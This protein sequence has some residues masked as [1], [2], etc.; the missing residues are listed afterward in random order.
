MSRS[1]PDHQQGSPAGPAYPSYQQPQRSA[2]PYRAGA[3]KPF[4]SQSS[5][6]GYNVSND[7]TYSQGH[8]VSHQT[9]HVREVP[10]SHTFQPFSPQSIDPFSQ[11]TLYGSTVEPRGGAPP[12][13]QPPSYFQVETQR[14]QVAYP[15]GQQV[16]QIPVHYEGHSKQSENEPKMYGHYDVH[17]RAQPC[18]SH[19]N[20]PVQKSDQNQHGAGPEFDQPMGHMPGQNGHFI[21]V[22][23]V[24]TPKQPPPPSNGQ[25]GAEQPTQQAGYRPQFPYSDQSDDLQYSQAADVMS[26]H[27]TSQTPMS[28]ASDSG[29]PCTPSMSSSVSE[30]S[31]L[32]SFSEGKQQPGGQAQMTTGSYSVA[33]SDE[34]VEFRPVTQPPAGP[35]AGHPP[36]LAV[37]PPKPMAPSPPGVDDMQAYELPQT[38]PGQEYAMHE[39]PAPHHGPGGSDSPPV[40]LCGPAISHSPVE[41]RTPD[42][43]VDEFGPV[44]AHEPV[45]PKTPGEG[46]QM[47]FSPQPSA[48]P[49]YNDQAPEAVGDSAFGRQQSFPAPPPPQMEEFAPGMEAGYSRQNSFPLPPPPEEQEQPQTPQE[50]PAPPT[51]ESRPEPPALTQSPQPPPPPPPPPLPLSLSPK[52]NQP[53]PTSLSPNLQT[54]PHSP[55]APGLSPGQQA[56]GLSPRQ[57]PPG[58]SPRHV[59]PGLS[60][61]LSPL[62][63]SPGLSPVPAPHGTG[64]SPVPGAGL[65]PIP[66]PPPMH[67]LSPHPVEPVKQSSPSLG[68]SSAGVPKPF[69]PGTVQS[70]PTLP[71]ASPHNISPSAAPPIPG[72]P[73]ASLSPPSQPPAPMS[74]SPGSQSSVT[75]PGSLGQP[76]PAGSLEQP[77]P[78]TT[79]AYSPNLPWLQGNKPQSSS[80]SMEHHPQDQQ[81]PALHSPQVRPDEFPLVEAGPQTEKVSEAPCPPPPVA[82]PPP[83]PP[84]PPPMPSA[85]LNSWNVKRNQAPASQGQ[86][87]GQVTDARPSVL[88]VDSLSLV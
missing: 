10:V 48:P 64:Q 32:S 15:A 29:Y 28:Q 6:D 4:S 60:P 24:H 74:S 11:P 31:D 76:S 12:G 30:L 79:R 25:Y 70:E 67:G 66:P 68:E 3:P 57:L 88:Q 40:E 50:F 63:V 49:Y 75:L 20:I 21:P 22:Q 71:Q 69:S 26:G 38:T 59:S 8:P 80:P 34:S 47:P 72:S 85:P 17:Q 36:G 19:T 53:S 78:D 33:P 16:H 52:P 82:P 44:V 18:P 55:Q 73:H 43:P 87:P 86:G 83:P 56:P 81:T 23:V 46:S 13:I 7:Y 41:P 54:S 84:P 9:P 35:P 45:T 37:C 1:L 39:P 2:D 61:G 51:P 42:E 77:A 65:S 5:Y 27:E 62:H 58:M 14:Q